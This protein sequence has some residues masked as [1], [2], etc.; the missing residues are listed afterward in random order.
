MYYRRKKRSR[1]QQLAAQHAQA[2]SSVDGG[3]ALADLGGVIARSDAGPFYPPIMSYGGSAGATLQQQQHYYAN[4]CG[5]PQRSGGGGVDQFHYPAPVGDQASAAAAAQ[6]AA[7]AAHAQH[8]FNML[9]SKM[10]NMG[11]CWF[12]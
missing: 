1:E 11:G 5:G 10:A 4:S 7:Q 12:C 3:V 9:T 8:Q 2:S 6:A